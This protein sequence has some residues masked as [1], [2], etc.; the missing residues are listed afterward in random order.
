MSTILPSG[1]RLMLILSVQSF[2]GYTHLKSVIEPDPLSN[3]M[4]ER[5]T[6]V[7]RGSVATGEGFVLNHNA[8][9]MRETLVV[10]GE[11]RASEQTF[12]LCVVEPTYLFSTL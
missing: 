7:E 12:S 11:S 4:R 3:F 8:I 1:K 10:R 6:L 9:I 2:W 5:L